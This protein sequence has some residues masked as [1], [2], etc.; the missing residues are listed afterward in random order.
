MIKSHN[1]VLLV[2]LHALRTRMVTLYGVCE[3]MRVCKLFRDAV[4]EAVKNHVQPCMEDQQA[5]AFCLSM[6]HKNVFITGGAGTGKSY[7]LQVIKRE[8]E[9]GGVCT[10]VVAPTGLAA[11]NVSGQTTHELFCILPRRVGDFRKG[12]YPSS[13]MTEYKVIL[14]P[15]CEPEEVGDG[16]LVADEDLSVEQTL[17]PNVPKEYQSVA[18]N[19][20]KSASSSST[21][22]GA[23]DTAVEEADA[24]SK[25]EEI[26]DVDAADVLFVPVETNLVKKAPMIWNIETL[27]VD[28]VSMM[29]DLV[30]SQIIEAL[31]FVYKL[32]VR[33][34]RYASRDDCADGYVKFGGGPWTNVDGTDRELLL[35]EKRYHILSQC[36][37]RNNPLSA[38][39]IIFVGDFAQLPPIYRGL[40]KDA[41]DRNYITQY[42]FQSSMWRRYIRPTPIELD[43]NKRVNPELVGW[44]ELINKI[45]D[46]QSVTWGQLM[47]WTR[48]TT[49]KNAFLTIKDSYKTSTTTREHSSIDLQESFAILPHDKRPGSFSNFKG[50]KV[51]NS[52]QY[53]DSFPCV[54]NWNA[55][56][57]EKL[58]GPTYVFEPVLK[59]DPSDEKNTLPKVTVADTLVLKHGCTVQV[60]KNQYSKNHMCLPDG[61]S[62]S[63]LQNGTL[64]MFEGVIRPTKPNTNIDSRTVMTVRDDDRATGIKMHA[65]TTTADRPIEYS[66]YRSKQHVKTEAPMTLQVDSNGNFTM[67]QSAK[68]FLKAEKYT[69][70]LT[71][72]N[73]VT[74]HKVQGQT[75]TMDYVI[76][77]VNCFE[78]G[79]LYVI[80]TRSSPERM[81]IDCNEWRSEW[82]N[83]ENG[84][85]HM[86]DYYDTKPVCNNNKTP[87]ISKRVLEFHQYIRQSSNSLW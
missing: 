4:L 20:R 26:D 84:L 63:K 30:L 5:K 1:E 71:C 64:A 29:N 69:F 83:T 80:L 75:I 74:V 14:A 51:R 47:R 43:V 49:H 8:L 7:T 19:S 23:I 28:E 57:F 60:T 73:G 76:Y 46:G 36:V 10:R 70:N 81:R 41:R 42:V 17:K 21:A 13:W 3:Y 48:Q 58:P 78:P 86:L 62:A 37:Q 24:D 18:S 16:R 25:D 77:P 2:L 11:V 45:R 34:Y 53:I 15:S 52:Q 87:L 55:I 33:K 85:Q 72:A 56:T 65:I 66:M 54:Q 67:S 35:T 32:V 6:L 61:L 9:I 22:E 59:P 50:N 68:S 12:T 39:N 82:A 31:N 44:L 79:M 40:T 38:I 27:I